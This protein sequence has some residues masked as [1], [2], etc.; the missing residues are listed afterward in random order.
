MHKATGEFYAEYFGY[1]KLRLDFRWS[2]TLYEIEDSARY[3]PFFDLHVVGWNRISEALEIWPT[4][5]RRTF[6]PRD[7]AG[8]GAVHGGAAPVAGDTDGGPGAVDPQAMSLTCTAAA[9][10]RMA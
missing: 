2:G 6:R 7:A 3:I 8:P 10:A 1:S 4:R 5:T 9:Q